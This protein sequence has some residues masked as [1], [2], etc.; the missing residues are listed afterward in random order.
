MP[1]HSMHKI[2][3]LDLSRQNGFH[4]SR[5]A[6]GAARIHADHDIA[7]R[8]PAFGIGDLPVLILVGRALQNLR[9]IG[10]HLLPLHG[11]ALLIGE[12]LGVN[13]IGQDHGIPAIGNGPENVGTEVDA[14]IH[15]NGR[16]P[17]DTHSIPH[18]SSHLDFRYMTELAH[19]S[20]LHLIKST[21]SYRADVFEVVSSGHSLQTRTSF[22]P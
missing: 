21:Y 18:F 3:V 12:A 22:H 15:N 5:R 1:A 10:D 20:I 9:M 8:Y 16:V 14:V 17:V 13:S 19:P 6:T 2:E 11:I 7:M 4:E